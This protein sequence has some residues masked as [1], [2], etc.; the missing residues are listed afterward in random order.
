MAHPDSIKV[1]VED[2]ANISVTSS[3]MLGNVAVTPETP[4][5]ISINTNSAQ[6]T[7]AEL[8]GGNPL[9]GQVIVY[10]STTNT[11]IYEYAA[12]TGGSLSSDLQVTNRDVAY[13]D[14][15]GRL[16]EEGDSHET[17][18]RDLLSPNSPVIKSVIFRWNKV[19]EGYNLPANRIF[20]LREVEFDFMFPERLSSSPWYISVDGTV[21]GGSSSLPNDYGSTSSAKVPFSASIGE[22][23]HGTILPFRL[24]SSY[25]DEGVARFFSYEGNLYFGRGAFLSVSNSESDADQ[26]SVLAANYVS[27]S[28]PESEET[29]QNEIVLR[30]STETESEE[31]YTWIGVPS[32]MDISSISEEVGGTGVANRTYSFQRVGTTY[33]VPIV[34][35]AYSVYLYRSNQ[36]GALS[37]Q[38]SLRIKLNRS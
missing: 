30:G 31:N 34:N 32:T 35:G 14:A 3:P 23:D 13:G 5:V 11:F 4:A 26:M 16:Y 8:V 20:G 28:S 2:A 19:D 17:I 37:A 18:I 21:V 24:Y 10:D 36:K 7:L 9:D 38:S 25:D 33:V 1:I 27:F 29:N 22:N 12:G 15:V 6:V